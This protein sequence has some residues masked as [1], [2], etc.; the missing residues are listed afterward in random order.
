MTNKRALVTG[1]SSGFGKKFVE[2]LL[3]DPKWSVVASLRGG[4]DRARKVFSAEFLTRVG[5]RLQF[6]DLE[7]GT[8]LDAKTLSDTWK[9]QFGGTL[10]LIV[11]NAGYGM[12]G[13]SLEQSLPDIRSQFEVNFFSPITLIHALLPHF[14]NEGGKVINLS[15]ICGLATFPF[16]GAYCSSKYAL[17]AYT[18]A[19]Q[20]ELNRRG[21]QFCLVEPG[22]FR[23]EFN[24]RAN[25]ELH[26]PSHALSPRFQFSKEKEAFGQF[27]IEKKGLA[28][29]PQKVVNLLI[30]LSNQDSLP[31]RATVGL[32]AKVMSMAKK[33]LPTFL[34]TWIMNIVF[35]QVSSRSR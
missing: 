15:S 10:D 8:T 35:H 14:P 27:L 4:E 33:F 12:L 1:T 29:D 16:Y 20:Y 22:A 13:P 28:G 6:W 5:N 21:I 19:L 2:Q 17:E 24:Q 25:T 3:E 30:R 34:W 23:T 18:E 26:R 31:L 7:L 32:D 9:S 11:N